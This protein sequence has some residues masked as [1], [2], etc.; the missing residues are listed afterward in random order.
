MWLKDALGERG[1]SVWD[2]TSIRPGEDWSQAISDAINACDAVVL[3]V[4]PNYLKSGICNF[5]MGM[6]VQAALDAPE[7]KVVP[8]LLEGSV[9]EQLPP[10]VRQFPSMKAEKKNIRLLTAQMKQGKRSPR[11]TKFRRI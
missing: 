6:V 8:F 7:K 9:S 5:E 2:D 1:L 3:L 10:P 4:S 11:R